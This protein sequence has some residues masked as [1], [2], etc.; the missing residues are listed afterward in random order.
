MSKADE[1]KKLVA[2]IDKDPNPSHGDITPA[3][4]ALPAYGIDIIPYLRAPLSSPELPTRLRA[5][6]A[7]AQTISRHCGWVQGK[8][9]TR[10]GGEA[11]SRALWVKNGSYR[12]DGDEAARAK[13]I[14]EWMAW[15]RAQTAN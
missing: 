13:S 15:Y 1:I 4:Q 12:A 5:E 9:W 7:L 8:G 10:E 2:E 11:E 3:T 6:G 14:E